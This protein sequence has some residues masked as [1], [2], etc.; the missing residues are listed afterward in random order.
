MTRSSLA[1]EILV[2]VGGVNIGI[3]IWSTLQMISQKAKH[4]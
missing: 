3:A 4:P 2:R 1:S